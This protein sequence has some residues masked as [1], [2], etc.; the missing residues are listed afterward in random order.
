MPI[1]V[2]SQP[3][4]WSSAYRPTEFLFASDRLPNTTLGDVNI[5]IISIAADSLGVRV[6][7]ASQFTTGDLQAGETILIQGTGLGLYDGRYRVRSAAVSG[8]NLIAYIDTPDAG[9]DGGGT[10]SRTYD[11][12]VLAG[13]VDFEG[14]G[15]V[16]E[17]EL[18]PDANNNHFFT[19]NVQD[20]A[21]RQFERVFDEVQPALAFGAVGN[22]D[23][24]I[25]QGFTVRVWER[26]TYWQNGTPR[27]V[28]DRKDTEVKMA[29]FI[30]VNMIHPYHKSEAFTMDWGT[31]IGTVFPMGAGSGPM[32]MLSWGS[33]TE[34]MV[35]NGED[36]YIS[37][38]LRTEFEN[39]FTIAVFPYNGNSQIMTLQAQIIGTLPRYAA[40]FNVGPSVLTVLSGAD[41]YKVRILDRSGQDIMEP[42]T[43]LYTPCIQ[44]EANR[45]VW[46]RN[47][48]GG[49][50][51]YT[52]R[53]RE[54]DIPAVSRESISR[55]HNPIPSSSRYIGGWNE[56]GYRV[57][58]VRSKVITTLLIHGD[59]ARW[60]KQDCFESA[61]HATVV[62]AGWWTPMVV[63]DNEA[64]STGTDGIARRFA[65]NF[66][67][68]VDNASQRG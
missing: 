33:R 34:Q 17:F 57:E 16:V 20:M 27:T 31:D 8:A 3:T 47:K 55:V 49:L 24:C 68:G 58:P 43:L 35:T 29:G 5:A 28:D 45:R 66:H 62:R 15:N 41:R 52:F 44:S 30:T 59:E 36:F 64:Q 63:E 26:F 11:G 1:G 6:I 65:L 46:W 25:A 42:L 32:R 9:A 37:V 22:G 7:I 48:L 2:V 19:L 21:A 12:L 61:D 40:V 13:T 67:Y 39:S 50:D 38:L 56:R 4:K 18:K 60:L 54:M 23:R 10:A 53:G 51:Q 14:S